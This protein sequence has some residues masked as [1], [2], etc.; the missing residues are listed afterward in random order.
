MRVLKYVQ[1]KNTTTYSE[2]ADDIV[3]D[4]NFGEVEV[5]EKKKPNESERKKA[6][7]VEEEDGGVAR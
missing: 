2:C 6:K 3:K 5:V 1:E 4:S 7:L